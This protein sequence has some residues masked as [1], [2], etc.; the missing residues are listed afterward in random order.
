[1]T[2]RDIQKHKLVGTLLF[3]P[4]SDLDGVSGILEIDKIHTLDH[5]AR[6]NV[7]TGNDTLRQHEI[8][9]RNFAANA[10]ECIAVSI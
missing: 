10:T 1:M 4:L 9:F 8:G 3:V 6:V 7:K 2:G 5:S